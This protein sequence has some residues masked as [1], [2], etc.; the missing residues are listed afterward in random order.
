MICACGSGASQSSL[1]FFA[2]QIPMGFSHP[3]RPF[4]DGYYPR[5]KA[6]FR[7]CVDAVPRSSSWGFKPRPSAPS[8]EG[9]KQFYRL[10]HDNR[11]HSGAGRA[12]VAFL[13]PHFLWRVKENGVPV[14]DC[15]C[16]TMCRRH[17]K[18]STRNLNKA[19]TKSHRMR[20]LFGTDKKF[21]FKRPDCALRG[22]FVR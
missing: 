3:I 9:D 18:S 4:F 20:W 1:S 6:M 5:N 21:S 22:R 16:K 12:R 8:A 2:A 14:A 19:K 10:A 13:F 17:L 7:F 11:G 15:D